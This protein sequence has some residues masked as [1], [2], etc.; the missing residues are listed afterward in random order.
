[1]KYLIIYKSCIVWALTC[2]LDGMVQL[3]CKDYTSD[4][5]VTIVYNVV[6]KYQYSLRYIG[7]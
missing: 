3:G 5:E 2:L 1:M 7:N 4:G 6:V